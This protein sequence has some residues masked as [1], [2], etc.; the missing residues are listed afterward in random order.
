MFE[1]FG[2]RRPGPGFVFFA[3]W[4]SRGE[5]LLQLK[6][7]PAVD[8]KKSILKATLMRISEVKQSQKSSVGHKAGKPCK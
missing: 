6:G 2:L 5:G 4:P 7:I 1:G 3:S 8:V